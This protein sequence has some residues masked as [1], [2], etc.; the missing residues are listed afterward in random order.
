M[1]ILV[2]HHE[3][4]N[5]PLA[6]ILFYFDGKGHDLEPVPY[7]GNNPKKDKPRH[8]T[9]ASVRDTIRKLS[10]QGLKVKEIFCKL[11]DEVGGFEGA[12]SANDI[13]NSLDQT[14]EISK[15]SKNKTDELLEILDTP[16]SKRNSP[17]AF[18]RD[19]HNGDDFSIFLASKQQLQN[20][21]RFCLE[22]CWSILDVDPTFN[23]CDCNVT[24]TTYN[25]P[26]TS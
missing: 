11:R 12:R 18:V 10:M 16:A 15:K 23:I 24:V 14:Y 4:G 25:L 1:I 21:K 20:L 5:L 13:L 26:V 2:T 9:N 8:S 22:G 6:Y 3:E 7:H 17:N 19:V